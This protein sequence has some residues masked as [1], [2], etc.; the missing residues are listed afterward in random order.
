MNALA[1]NCRGVGNSRTVRD[2]A[3]LV[4]TYNPKL[5]FLSETRQSEEQM[6]GLRWRLGLKG[7]LARSSVGRSG[8]IALF[9]EESLLVDLIT[10]SNKIIDVSVQ[11]CPSSQPW[12][13]TFIY[14]EPRVEDRHLTW[15][16]MKRIKYRSD[17]PWIV[18]GDFN[19][20]MWQFEHFSET[21]RGERQ[22][23]AFRDTLAICDLFDLGFSGVPW[24]YDNKQAGH[25]NVR[26][27]LDRAVATA[28]WSDMFEHAEVEH[29]TSPCSDHCPVL[30]KVVPVVSGR[31]TQ[32]IL[33]YEIM[34]EREESLGDV[35]MTSWDNAPAKSDLSSVASALRGVMHSL[36]DW[37]K[38]K[39]GS[40]RKKLEELRC[41]LS[42]LQSRMDDDSR[43]QAKEVAREMNEMLYREEMMW[44]QRSRISWLREGDK[45]TKFFHQKAVWRSRKN[46]I[47]RLK[48]CNGQW[49]DDPSQMASMATD[50]FGSLYTKDDNV[51]PDL[52]IS[53]LDERISGEM[54]AV[55]CKEFS[56]KEIG[57]ALFQIGPLKAPGPDGFPARFFQ[58]NW[59]LIK[60]DIVKAVKKFF[61]D[62]IM[63]D[64]V[65]D[66]TIVLIPK[67]PHPEFLSDFR[68]ISLCNV[69]YK[70][71]SKC[72]VNRLRPLLQDIISPHQSAFIPG[73]LI[74][75]NALIAFECLHA[76]Q[77]SQ[78]ARTN[79]CAFKLDLSKA[80]DRVDWSFF[81]KSYAE[82]WF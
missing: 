35:I 37:S 70:V 24:T 1:W 20:A 50:F 21:K 43:E 33:R 54:N 36:H 11:E 27:R 73:R 25:R 15:E 76:I 5:V 19:E 42:D 26:V 55:L 38:E 65:N 17:K 23:E 48:A 78:S 71:V 45:N 66:T 68:P 74:T 79:F 22:M 13:I 29:L 59:G 7:C 57:D 82:A 81:G 61:S 44:L 31:T 58:R 52:L 49:C 16:L 14:G 12:R 63:P 32:K 69:L 39:F 4:Q 60:E 77:H 56:D 53:L 41:Q 46:R 28:S 8:G 62:G 40:V 51:N 72:L 2:L 9:W 34:W 80:Y 47:R 30:L 75:D 64:E 67:V 10:I 6:K 18:V 3:A